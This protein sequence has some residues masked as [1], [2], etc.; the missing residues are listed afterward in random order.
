MI[1]ATDLSLR[2]WAVTFG[3]PAIREIQQEAAAM[4]TKATFPTLVEAYFTDRLIR[5]RQASPNTI[6]SH[7]DTF[8]LLLGFAQRTLKKGPSQLM[9]EDLAPCFIGSF[10]DHLEKERGNAARTRN[11][12]LAAIHSF[13]KFA[14]LEEPR[15][16]ALA[17]R[18]L[19]IPNKRFKRKPI[20]FLTQ[21]EIEALLAAPDQGSWAGCRDHTLLLLAVQTGLRVSELVGLRLSD[22]S[23]GTGAYVRCTGKGRKERCTPLRR[24][25]VRA[26]RAWF[27][28]RK[29]EPSDT[30]FPNARGGPLSR[31]GVE[32]LLA[33]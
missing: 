23:L 30:L 18:V 7:R 33:K 6:A 22:V 20:E 14:A 29:G 2:R 31:D 32:Y 12:R 8:R 16:V 3:D 5:Q 21:E 17:Q 4:T 26:L 1:F 11:V 13:F 19:A 25:T 24:D 10:L 27:R 15:C 28:R 9:V